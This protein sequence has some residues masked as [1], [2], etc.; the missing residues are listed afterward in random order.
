MDGAFHSA[1]HAEA[2]AVRVDFT[3]EQHIL[4]EQGVD[5]WGGFR[6]GFG[7]EDGHR[8]LLDS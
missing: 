8:Y 3:L 6:L 1:L 5:G 4:A 7:A 2:V